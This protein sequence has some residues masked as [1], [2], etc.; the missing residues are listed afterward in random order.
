MEQESSG[1]PRNPLLPRNRENPPKFKRNASMMRTRAAIMI[2]KREI[3]REKKELERLECLQATKE[4][5]ESME[6]SAFRV[7]VLSH[8]LERL[9]DLLTS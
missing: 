8:E 9:E 5:V 1:S 3:I 6:L 4:T 7:G 2:L